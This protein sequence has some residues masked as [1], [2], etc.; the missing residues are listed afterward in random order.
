M[1]TIHTAARHGP[2]SL[3]TY[4]VQSH[5]MDIN[6]PDDWGFGPIYYALLSHD[7]TMV[8]HLLSLGADLDRH[9]LGWE[10][11][12]HTPIIWAL[13]HGENAAVSRLLVA[14]AKTW[15][16][17][18]GTERKAIL[19]HEIDRHYTYPSAATDTWSRT[20]S[21][22]AMRKLMERTLEEQS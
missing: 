3:V 2:K 11:V 12:H 10:S 8:E 6:E 14:G 13:S 4:L 18:G 20:Q 5:G 7:N 19:N 16:T 17:G 22:E 1:T 15:W 9:D 21:T